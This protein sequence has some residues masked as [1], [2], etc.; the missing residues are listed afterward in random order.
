[1]SSREDHANVLPTSYVLRSETI[2][3]LLEE[4]MRREKEKQLQDQ[5]RVAETVL[6]QHNKEFVWA[7]PTYQAQSEGNLI[8]TRRK[9]W[10]LIDQTEDVADDESMHKNKRLRYCG[11]QTEN[12]FNFRMK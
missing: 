6:S 3:E 2:A 9:S 1:M 8:P 7:P 5:I 10:V 4:G 11:A 12:C